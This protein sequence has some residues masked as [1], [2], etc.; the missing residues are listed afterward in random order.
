LLV[1][2]LAASVD[3]VVVRDDTSQSFSSGFGGL[4]LKRAELWI[5]F[6]WVT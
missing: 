3:F 4:I 6:K 1:R 5:I 2:L